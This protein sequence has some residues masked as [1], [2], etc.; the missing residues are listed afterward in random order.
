MD[1]GIVL[2]GG[3]S[4]RMGRPKA[5]LDWHGTP[6]VVHMCEV[7]RRSTD[8]L[9]VVAA[10]PGQELPSL[11]AEVEVVLDEAVGLGPLE[12]LRVGLRALDGRVERVFAAAVDL[13]LLRPAV[14]RAVL[15]ALP[16]GCDA[17]VPIAGGFRQPLAAAYRP[18]LW[19]QI[20]AFL[21][22]GQRGLGR[23]LDEARTRWLA[24]SVLTALD[25]ELSSLLNVNTLAD[26]ELARS[27]EGS[28]GT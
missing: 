23:L 20:D 8:G 26:L 25:P 18:A 2:A 9:V 15:G 4:T 11:P 6:L 12:G 28:T 10:A 22:A 5:L 3:A 13:P 21:A 1:G 7:L 16:A 19:R 27:S 24:E 14:I 17:S